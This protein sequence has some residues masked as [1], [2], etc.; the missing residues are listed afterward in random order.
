MV[1]FIDR[2]NGGAVIGTVPVSLAYSSDTRIGTATVNWPVDIGTA[3]TKTFTVGIA[4]GGYY[5]RISSDDIALVTVAKPLD[6]LVT[7]GGFLEVPNS[8]GIAS[9][10]VGARNDFGFGVKYDSDDSN[11]RGSVTTVVRSGGRVYQVSGTAM[12]SLSVSTTSSGGTA[13]FK[14]KGNIVDITYPLAPSVVDANASLQVSVT[15]AG[16]PGSADLLGVTVLNSSGALWFSSNWNGTKTVK[17]VLSAGNIQVRGSRSSSAPVAARLANPTQAAI[18]PP[19]VAIPVAFAFPQNYPNPFNESTNMRFELP[20]RS[21]V[22]L[23][24]YDV[25]GREV[26]NLVDREIEAGYH[27]ES[28]TGRNQNGQPLSAGVYLVRMSARS[29]T[30]TGGLRADRR[31]VLVR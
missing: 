18:S 14:A 25:S 23:T 29:V 31:V 21:R 1:S 22:T 3:D 13:S 26:A 2:D 12:S 10:P 15:D 28:W 20:E 5:S 6:K 11:P 17:Q 7:G 30:G 27:M 8:A 9:S 4:V 24:I 16:E 19:S